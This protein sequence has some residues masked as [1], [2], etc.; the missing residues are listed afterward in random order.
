[1][2]PPRQ[3]CHA[4]SDPV[5]IDP[6]PASGSVGL[7]RSLVSNHP[8]RS[9]RYARSHSACD[10]SARPA[11]GRFHERAGQAHSANPI[12]TAPRSL[13]SAPA[14]ASGRH[15]SRRRPSPSS[16]GVYRWKTAADT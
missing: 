16:V 7:L 6:Q 4:I 10:R 12:E 2:T 15:P 1:M 11:A 8:G 13:R 9:R 5:G 3:Q 14:Q